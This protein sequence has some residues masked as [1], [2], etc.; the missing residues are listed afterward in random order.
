MAKEDLDAS[1]I[2]FK[3]KKYLNICFL[4]LKK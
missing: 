4:I 1:S 2:L 3:K